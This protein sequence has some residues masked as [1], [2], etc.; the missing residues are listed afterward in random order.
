MSASLC[1]HAVA[2]AP[3]LLLALRVRAAPW[4]DGGRRPEGRVVPPR[5]RTRD[6]QTQQAVTESS[7][8]LHRRAREL[9]HGGRARECLRIVE[10]ALREDAGNS[11][12]LCL[13]AR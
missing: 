2:H 4:G 10:D 12:F 5:T 11:Y 13:G 1:L 7:A 3:R 6:S 8:A 9:L